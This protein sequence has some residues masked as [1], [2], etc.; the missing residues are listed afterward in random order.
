MIVAKAL[1]TGAAGFIGSHVVRALVEEGAR[2]RA[3]VRPG[4]D[5]RNL[6]GVDVELVEGD[7]RSA[8]DLDRGLVGVGGALPGVTRARS[9]RRRSELRSHVRDPQSAGEDRPT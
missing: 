8:D 4:E 9:D 7:V 1:V 6:R 3:F 2:V 5:L